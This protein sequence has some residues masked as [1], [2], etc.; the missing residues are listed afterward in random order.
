MKAVIILFWICGF[1]IIG[2]SATYLMLAE[3][4]WAFVVFF[5]G[6]LIAVLSLLMSEIREMGKWLKES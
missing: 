5:F 3:N 1:L 6:V 4:E 2:G